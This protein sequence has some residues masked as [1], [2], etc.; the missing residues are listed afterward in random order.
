MTKLRRAGYITAATAKHSKLA[1]RAKEECKA[2]LKIL[3]LKD[4][5][6]VPFDK[7]VLICRKYLA[8]GYYSTV[9]GAGELG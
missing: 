1:E 6:S 9:D 7:K 5:A 8:T 2:E 3:G 4:R